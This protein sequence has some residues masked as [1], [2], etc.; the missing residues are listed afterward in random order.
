M[1]DTWTS[2]QGLQIPA[3]PT[4]DAGIALKD[5]LV[6]LADRDHIRPSVKIVALSNL[7]SLSG[8]Q[9]VEGM[10]L[11]AGDRILLTAQTT[12]TNNG[13]WVVQAATWTRPDDAATDVPLSGAIYFSD[14]AASGDEYPAQS[15]WRCTS[16]PGSDAVGTD[17]LAFTQIIGQATLSAMAPLAISDNTIALTGVVPISNGGTNRST[18]LTNNRIM[19]SSAGAIVAGPALTSGQLLIGS[20]GAAPVAGSLTGTSHQITVI[21]SAGGITLSLPSEVGIGTTSPDQKLTVSGSGARINVRNADTNYESLQLGADANQVFIA[22]EKSGTASYVPLVFKTGGQEKLRL[23]TSNIYLTGTTQ[24][25]GSLNVT[26]AL[27]AAINILQSTSASWASATAMSYFL[28]AS[29]GSNGWYF[30]AFQSGSGTPSIQN[31]FT[32]RGDG[33]AYCTGTWQAGG[34]DYA[35]HFEWADGNPAHEDRTGY[36]VSL[37]GNKIRP[38]ASGDVVIGVVTGRPTV[39][40]D[41]A[42]L[43]W[44]GKFLTDDYGRVLYESID[45][46]EWDEFDHQG[47]I[48][49]H[50]SY[51]AD[52]VPDGVVVPETAIRTPVERRQLNPNFNPEAEYVPREQRPEWA[53]VGLMGKLRLRAGQPTAS[54]WIKL[55]NVAEGIEEWFVK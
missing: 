51:Q 19:V 46:V 16:A 54:D 30:Q 22:A 4:G 27:P 15:A 53:C 34:A 6:T 25:S 23:E 47:H 5:D 55:R 9:T 3:N 44:Q 17:S 50:H 48:V 21:P 41:G 10:A 26:S 35:E 11:T 40:G 39:V 37:D 29:A 8:P 32:F 12:A 33:V 1:S 2:Y 45:S 43:H 28:N 18:A 52:Q 14:N 13:P 42:F 49:K 7:A 31:E 38:A 20:T 36:S 24:I